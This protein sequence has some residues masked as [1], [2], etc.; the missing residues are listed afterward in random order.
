MAFRK[1][2]SKKTIQVEGHNVWLHRKNVKNLNLRVYPAEQKIRI[3][4]P[5]RVPEKA[6]IQFIKEKLPWIR[7]QL[8]KTPAITPKPEFQYESG[9]K[10]SIWGH[11]FTLEINE[12]NRTPSVEIIEEKELILLK[13]RPGSSKKKRASIMKE[14]YRG[15]LKKE[16][17]KLIS[18]WEPEMKVSVAE[19]GVKQMKTRWGTC[20][21]RDRRIW[22]NLELAKKRPELLEYVVVHE[23]VHLL[24]RLHNKRFHRF[25]T[26]YLPN[27]KSLKNELNGKSNRKSC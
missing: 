13:V 11:Q 8:N 23:M 7:K 5:R 17:P 12:L 16:I 19:F 27:W 25:M 26:Q 20:N 1:S 22:L 6:I 14:W 2:F 18:K 4:V 21:I 3:S 15:E 10:H 9:E 24:E